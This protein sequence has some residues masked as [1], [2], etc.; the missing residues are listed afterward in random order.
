MLEII[1][2]M[3]PPFIIDG[4]TVTVSYA[5]HDNPPKQ[6][7]YSK[8][9]RAVFNCENNLPFRKVCVWLGESSV[10]AFRVTFAVSLASVKQQCSY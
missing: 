2:N 10:S 3:Q 4:R 9:I 7:R 1:S 5:K 8:I 6:T